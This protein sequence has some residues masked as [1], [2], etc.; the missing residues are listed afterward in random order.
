MILVNLLRLI[1]LLSTL[2]LFVLLNKYIY[3]S[4]IFKGLV[5]NDPKN[6]DEM[7]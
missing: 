3:E 6:S 7:S 5:E 2:I 1:L 4:D